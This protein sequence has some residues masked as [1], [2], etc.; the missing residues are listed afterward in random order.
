MHRNIL[1]AF[2]LVIIST[3][4]DFIPL[5]IKLLMIDLRLMFANELFGDYCEN[6]RLPSD[7]RINHIPD[8]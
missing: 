2:D 8:I 5:V 6:V 4:G 7:D 1:R 3:S